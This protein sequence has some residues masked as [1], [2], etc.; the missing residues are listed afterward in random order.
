MLQKKAF[1][2]TH[3]KKPAKVVA[4]KFSSLILQFQNGRSCS[5]RKCQACEYSC[6]MGRQ[7]TEIRDAYLVWADQVKMLYYT[8]IKGVA[9]RS[10]VFAS[11]KAFL[12]FTS[13]KI[14]FQFWQSLLYFFGCRWRTVIAGQKFLEENMLKKKII[15]RYRSIIKSWCFCL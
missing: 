4:V 15:K 1:S 3:N 5:D 9:E 13:H 14:Y 10:S 6:A 12:C 11:E 7:K 8:S 2:S